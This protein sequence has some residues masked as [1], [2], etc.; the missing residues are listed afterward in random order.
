MKSYSE[1][2]SIIKEEF[3]RLKLK[4]R[5]VDIIDSFGRILAEDIVADIDLPPFNNSAVDG[6]AVQYNDRRS[7]KLIGEISAGNFTNLKVSNDQTV[8]ITTGA[9]LPVGTDTVIPLEDVTVAGNTIVLNGG[10][11]VKKGANVRHQGEDLRKSEIATKIYTKID[12]KVMS[13][14]AACG[15][16]V[17]KIFEPLKIG[18]LATGDELIPIEKKPE[19]DKLRVTNTYSLYGAVREA[20]QSPI[21]FGFVKYDKE[22]VRQRLQEIFDSNLDI[23]IT[24]GGVSVGKYDFLKML[25]EEEGVVTKCWKANVKPG[26]P[27]YFGVYVSQTRR[28]MVVG[29]PG[30]PVSSLVGFKVFIRPAIDYIFHQPLVPII[31]A[32]LQSPYKKNDNKRHFARGFLYKEEEIWKVKTQYSQSS[33][34]MVEMS[35]SNCLIVFKEEMLNPKE[36]ERVECILI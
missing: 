11:S 4:T 12:S 5:E 27:I 14:L 19:N 7:W 28:I 20:G 21:L 24:T 17:V 1:T 22:L 10:V 34:N 15:K 25:F 32:V 23:L 31:D 18:I 30:N 33:G 36:G 3:S 9:K 35:M 16:K 29:L 8:L 2:L 26:K 6:Y 13:T